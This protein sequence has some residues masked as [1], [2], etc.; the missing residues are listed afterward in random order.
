MKQ[1]AIVFCVGFLVGGVYMVGHSTGYE[2]GKRRGYEDGTGG[3]SRD[4]YSDGTN[5]NHFARLV[6]FDHKA[7]EERCWI[8]VT[9]NATNF[10][11]YYQWTGSAELLALAKV[12]AMQGSK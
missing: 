12:M 11:L 4:Y 7:K 5:R 6:E 8:R 3:I 1:I 2:K 9:P 10:G